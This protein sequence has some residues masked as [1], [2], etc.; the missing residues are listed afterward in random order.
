M[1]TSEKIYEEF[2]YKAAAAGVFNEWREK[3]SSIL[4]QEPGLRMV[5]AAEQ[6]YFQVIGS[7]NQND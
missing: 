4:D 1:A 6:A 3:T 7:E 2:G 5:D